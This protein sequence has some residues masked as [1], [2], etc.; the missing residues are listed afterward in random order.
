MVESECHGSHA[1][2]VEELERE[3]GVIPNARS[4][5]RHNQ[6]VEDVPQF[7]PDQIKALRELFSCSQ[8][9][10]ARLLGCSRP[11]GCVL[12]ADR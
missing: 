7:S 12:I 6:F 8:Q 9:Q 4:R 5:V 10:V 2:N 11:V 1:W 3:P